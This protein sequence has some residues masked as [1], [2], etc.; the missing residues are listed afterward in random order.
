[1]NHTLLFFVHALTVPRKFRCNTSTSPRHPWEFV[2]ECDPNN[3]IVSFRPILKLVPA[4]ISWT[5]SV[6]DVFLHLFFLLSFLLFQLC[7]PFLLSNL[8]IFIEI[9][10]AL[11]L[12]FWSLANLSLRLLKLAFFS[13][14]FRWDAPRSGAHGVRNFPWCFTQR[15]SWC[16][17][18]CIPWT[19]WLTLR[20]IWSRWTRWTRWTIF[21]LDGNWLGGLAYLALVKPSWAA[22]FGGWCGSAGILNFRFRLILGRWRLEWWSKQW[23]TA[24]RHRSHWYDG[25]HWWSKA[26]ER[27]SCCTGSL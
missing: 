10:V 5:T 6:G 19:C 7:L 25:C 26:S 16:I 8:M 12:R 15:L 24:K 1:M 17:F 3:V 2:D 18:C 22:I 4:K 11:L 27:G 20:A 9:M 23:S 14:R 21:R 13:W